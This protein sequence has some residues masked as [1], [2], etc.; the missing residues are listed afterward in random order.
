MRTSAGAGIELMRA[1]LRRS[2]LPH[3]RLTAT[4]LVLAAMAVSV[5]GAP[6]QVP[7]TQPPVFLG[8]DVNPKTINPFG[9]TVI[10]YQ[11]SENATVRAVFKRVLSGRRV[12]GRCRPPTR[13]NRT[14]PRCIRLR[15]VGALDQDIASNIGSIG[16]TGLMNGRPLRV[17]I[18]RIELTA[19][20]VA[21]NKSPKKRLRLRVKRP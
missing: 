19:T 14:R 16:F 2:Q 15:T 11:A 21:G 18:Y 8:A 17:G 9:S 13:R 4:A 3:P 1:G 12:R 10:T 5:S 20:D 7:D 6:A